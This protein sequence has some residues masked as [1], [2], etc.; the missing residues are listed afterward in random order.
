MRSGIDARFDESVAP[1]EETV[2]MKPIKRTI[3]IETN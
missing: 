1:L 2:Q 3:E